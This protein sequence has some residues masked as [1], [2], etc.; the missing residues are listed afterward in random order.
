MTSQLG[1]ATP[2]RWQ[3]KIDSDVESDDDDADDTSASL[4]VIKQ[5]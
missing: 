4:S 2:S 1:V 5:Y 3:I